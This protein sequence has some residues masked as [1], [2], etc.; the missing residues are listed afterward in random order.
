MK[1]ILLLLFVVWFLALTASPLFEK[2][3]S[4]WRIVVPERASE[5][6]LYAAMEL[7]YFLKRI[8]GA[9][10]AIKRNGKTDGKN[11]IVIATPES[12]PQLPAAVKSPLSIHAKYDG[13]LK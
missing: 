13:S 7:Q 6:E 9:E 10:L 4:N 5:T 2:R 1:K 11:A 12:F 3:V 8:S